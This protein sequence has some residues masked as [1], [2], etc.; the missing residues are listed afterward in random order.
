MSVFFAINILLLL[1]PSHFMHFNERYLSKEQSNVIKG[2]FLLLVFMSHFSG[3]APVNTKAD[4]F[5]QL[6]RQHSGQLLVTMFLFYSGYGIFVSIHN[7]GMNYVRSIPVNRLLKVLLHFDIAVVI[8]ILMQILRGNIY[9]PKKIML[10]LLGWDTVGNS[11]WYIFAMLV[12]YLITW[13]TFFA[14][15][16]RKLESL[17]GT[18]LLTILA[19]YFLS[20]FKDGYWYNTMLCFPA[21]MWYAFGKNKIEKKL[22]N[23]KV[24]GWIFLVVLLI[25]IMCYRIRANIVWYSV[26]GIVFSMG[27]VMFTMKVSMSNKFLEWTGKNL[28]GLYIMQRIPMILLQHT[29]FAEKYVYG[30]AVV[31]LVGMY[32]IGFVFSKMCKVVDLVIFKHN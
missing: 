20:V 10:S 19:M 30:Y 28:F 16:S 31:C 8:Y 4:Y 14:F 24:Y 22:K 23:N 32:V 21:G 27:I 3:Y 5:Y 25:F 18:T 1:V 26:W 13:V 7:K 11:N 2:F 29:A 9:N 12:L 17:I 6:W 15:D